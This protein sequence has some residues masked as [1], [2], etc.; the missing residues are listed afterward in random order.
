[1]DRLLYVAMNGAKHSL[2]QQ[3]VTTHNLAN[4][5]TNG[6]KAQNGV[7]RALPAFGPGAPTRTSRSRA[8]SHW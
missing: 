3:A 1:M 4:V 5:S 2:Y 6:Y 7:F 8:A